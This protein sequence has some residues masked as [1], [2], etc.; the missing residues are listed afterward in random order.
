MKPFISDED[1]E[2]KIIFYEDPHEKSSEE[3]LIIE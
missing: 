1:F 3:I 2:E